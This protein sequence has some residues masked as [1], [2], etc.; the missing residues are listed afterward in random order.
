MDFQDGPR[1]ATVFHPDVNSSGG[2]NLSRNKTERRRL[3]GLYRSDS[4]VQKPGSIMSVDK[5][6]PWIR[7]QTWMV[8][9]GG[10]RIF[11]FVFIL[12]HALVIGLGF[13][14]YL[15]KDNSVNARKTFGITFRMLI[16][17]SISSNVTS[18]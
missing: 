16:F 8:N 17:C 13:A 5:E 1:P 4:L 14:H 7:L 3:Q 15:L 18:I 2:A 12:L 10:R 6:K 11:F 9:E